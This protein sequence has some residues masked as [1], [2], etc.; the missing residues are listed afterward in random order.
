MYIIRIILFLKK[1]T[2]W[3]KII[4][5]LR[6]I[7]Q[8][9]DRAKIQSKIFSHNIQRLWHIILIIIK[10]VNLSKTSHQMKFNRL[11]IRFLFIEFDRV[12]RTRIDGAAFIIASL[13]FCFLMT[14]RFPSRMLQNVVSFFS[15]CTFCSFLLKMR[16]KKM[17]RYLVSS[18]WKIYW[19][20]QFKPQLS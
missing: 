13:L 19:K 5:L 12:H 10:I 11:K 3:S 6:K 7:S 18:Q 4:S 2:C 16:R 20:I 14:E 15:P 1:K 8:I 9:N 17:G